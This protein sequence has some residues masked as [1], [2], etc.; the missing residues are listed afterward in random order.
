[1][2]RTLDPES[3]GFLVTDVARLL[4]ADLDRRIAASGIDLRPGELRVL[5]QAARTGRIRQN[6]LAEL[7]GVEAMTVSNYVDRL[8]A[9][10][11]IERLPDPADRRAKL[12][13]LTDA[14][15]GVLDELKSLADAARNEYARGIGPDEWASMLAVLKRAR[16]NLS[17]ARIEARSAVE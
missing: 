11:L 9:R 13:A 14:A 7:I 2:P 3:F 5:A 17:D 8:E 12:V 16:C 1:M 4:R 6:R 15:D 10:G